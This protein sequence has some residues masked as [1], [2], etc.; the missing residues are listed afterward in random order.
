MLLTGRPLPYDA[1]VVIRSHSAG[2]DELCPLL[3]GVA[4]VVWG[5]VV[6]ATT[7]NAVSLACRRAGGGGVTPTAPCFV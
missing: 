4:R 2:R 1:V 6:S 3:R 7:L 5:I